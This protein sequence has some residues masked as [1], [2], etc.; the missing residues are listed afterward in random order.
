[1]LCNTTRKR[2]EHHQW[3]DLLQMSAL[4]C[5]VSSLLHLCICT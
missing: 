1:M 3:T 2:T 5:V 4:D